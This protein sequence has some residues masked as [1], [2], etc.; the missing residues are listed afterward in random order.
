[1]NRSLDRRRLIGV[2]GTAAT[3]SALSGSPSHARRNQQEGGEHVSEAGGPTFVL[4]HGAWHGGWCWKKLT[5]ILLESGARVFAPTLTGLGE[6]VHLLTPDVDLTTHITDVLNLLEYEDLTDIV[7]VGHSYGGMV[8]SG[9]I[10]QAEDRI[11]QAVYLDAFLPENG[12]AVRDYAPAEVLDDMVATQGDGWRLPSFMF[13]ADFGVTDP[14]DIAWVDARLGD[15]PY[16]TFT[17]PIALSTDES[18]VA[19]AFILT[20][21]DTFI[22]HAERAKFLGF[23]YREMFTAGHNSMVTQPGELA[24]MLLELAKG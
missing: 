12:K 24:T 16:A 10:D 18:P 22:P 23:T 6:R 21:Q 1:M 2:A 4:V 8:L 17:Q 19:K 9:V 11:H 5:A 7:L 15:Q 14:D 13:A 20:T 3:A